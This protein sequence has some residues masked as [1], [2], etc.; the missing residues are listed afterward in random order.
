LWNCCLH[1]NEAG[2]E[3]CKG[4]CE[5]RSCAIVVLC[6]VASQVSELTEEEHKVVFPGDQKIREMWKSLALMFFSFLHIFLFFEQKNC[7]KFGKIWVFSGVNSTN[8]P[9]ILISHIER[10]TM[11]NKKFQWI[12]QIHFHMQI[13]QKFVS[14]LT[15][16]QRMSIT[17][18]AYKT[19]NLD[20]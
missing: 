15:K 16:T 5:S 3:T 13:V 2:Y 10:K 17:I 9:E 19:K 18:M 4:H 1:E 14:H 12:L 8:C 20:E 6:C 7:G 11:L